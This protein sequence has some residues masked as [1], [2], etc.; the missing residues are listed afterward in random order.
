MHLFSVVVHGRWD[1][2]Q[3]AR[4]GNGVA[5]QA[6]VDVWVCV[7]KARP[8]YCLTVVAH[9]SKM[10]FTVSIRGRGVTLPLVSIVLLS[11]LHTSSHQAPS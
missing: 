3:P 4:Y 9:T 6:D 2:W 10:Q 1:Q 11:C 8:Q 5:P 7:S